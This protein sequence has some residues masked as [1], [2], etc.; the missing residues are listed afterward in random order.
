M[1]GGTGGEQ[2]DHEDKCSEFDKG[3]WR[4]E[5]VGNRWIM[6]INVVNLIRGCGGGNRWG[7]GGP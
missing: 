4:G 3:V 7:T 2:V 6:R 5:Q 1:E